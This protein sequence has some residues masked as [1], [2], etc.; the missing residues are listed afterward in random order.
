MKTPV[1]SE[2]L[3]INH[4]SNKSLIFGICKGRLQLKNKQDWAFSLAN[5]LYTPPWSGWLQTLAFNIGLQLLADPEEGA[6]T[7]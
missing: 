4:V 5:K 6:E 3:L 1:E 2:K 7:V